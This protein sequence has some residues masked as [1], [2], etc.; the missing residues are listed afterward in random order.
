MEKKSGVLIIRRDNLTGR[1]YAREGRVVAAFIEGGGPQN[2]EAVFWMLGWPK[3]TF[4]FSAVAV[5]MED[6]VKMS[7]SHLLLEGARRIDEA[8]MPR[9]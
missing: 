2:A 8:R 1:V 3:G 5:D 7:I 9:E 4:E 6:A